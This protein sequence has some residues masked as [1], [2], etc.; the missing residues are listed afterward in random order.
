MTI[1]KFA[2]IKQFIVDKIRSG[3]WQENQR[4]PSENELSTQFKVSRMTARRALS[5][6]TEA[7]I[8]TRSQGL[9]TFV[10]SFKSQSSL[11]EI[12]NIA[13][14]VKERNG[15]YNCNV[16]ILESINAIAPIAIALG[17]EVDSVVY[18]SVIV[19]NENNSPLQ[20][21]ERFVNPALAR[22]YLQQ[23][24]SDLTPHEYLSGVAPL[25][26]ARH[27]VE[28][29]MP[30]NEMCQWL[31]LYNEEPCLQVIRRTWSTNG[32]VSFARLVSPGSKYRLGGHLTFKK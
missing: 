3:A 30:N 23:N 31:N 32:I 26:Q 10:A 13:D 9:G 25:T 18:R 24:F 1:P 12:K 5:E 2:Q 8:L 7:G 4:V 21:E 15:N 28:A 11:L 29:I 22:G 6:L 19:H 16:L 20:L 27:T 17:V 14:E